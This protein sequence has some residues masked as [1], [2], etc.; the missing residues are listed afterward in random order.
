MK[1]SVP[2]PDKAIFG[3]RRVMAPYRVLFSMKG[4]LRWLIAGC[5]LGCI[6]TWL[7][8]LQ[9]QWMHTEVYILQPF[10]LAAGVFAALRMLVDSVAVRICGY[11]LTGLLLIVSYFEPHSAFQEAVWSDLF[12]VYVQDAGFLLH[13]ELGLVSG[14]GKTLL[15]FIGLVLMIEALYYLTIVK[16]SVSWFVAFLVS[17]V[18]V[19]QLLTGADVRWEAAG[20]VALGLS[21][22]SLTRLLQFY[23]EGKHPSHSMLTCSAI[24]L[25]VMLGLTGGTLIVSHALTTGY[26]GQSKVMDLDTLMEKAGWITPGHLS[27]DSLPALSGYDQDDRQLGQSL[28]P[29]HTSVFVAKTPHVTYWRGQSRALYSGKGWLN[30]GE[31][32][33]AASK[34][35]ESANFNGMAYAAGGEEIF[36]QT[37]QM[38]EGHATTVLFAGGPAVQAEAT[39][40]E[41]LAAVYYDSV[42][43]AWLSATSAVSDY[44]VTVAASSRNGS[45]VPAL[46]REDS[47]YVFPRPGFL[48]AREQ[49]VYTQLPEGLPV[50]VAELAREWTKE[51]ESEEMSILLLLREL[52]ARY[53]YR[54]TGSERP[55]KDMDFVDHFL[56]EQQWGYCDHFSTTFAVMLR[57]LGMPTRWVKGY[58]AGEVIAA[59]T[60]ETDTFE[61]EVRQ[62]DAHSW[63][64]VY[65]AGTGWIGLNPTPA[66]SDHPVWASLSGEPSSSETKRWSTADVFTSVQAWAGEWSQ[67]SM[68]GRSWLRHLSAEE[69]GSWAQA[70]SGRLQ[71]LPMLPDVSENRRISVAWILGIGL[72]LLLIVMAIAWRFGYP[73]RARGWQWWQRGVPVHPGRSP[74]QAVM[75]QLD[76]RWQRIF[77]RLGAR[78]DGE[79]LR[80]YASRISSKRPELEDR[81]RAW[82]QFDERFRYQERAP[83]RSRQEDV[84]QMTR[85]Y[86][87]LFSNSSYFS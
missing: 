30:D 27:T 52:S 20:T 41:E 13:G 53:S 36:Q 26:E 21:L 73:L 82:V 74:E 22:L 70:A 80:D 6:Y 25:V 29:D 5:L 17:Y 38:R 66:R 8:T 78:N 33:E 44:A 81:L 51:S 50:R 39:E 1:P 76:R 54:M 15:F 85:L 43:Q 14:Q 24:W 10:M 63:V 2:S 18:A 37:I 40:D 72:L 55:P 48:S 7:K 42:S 69:A 9:V 23:D 56:F 68:L 86:D 31:T 58:G 19:F 59:P 49:R 57:T 4:M 28:V 67:A 71:A 77:R 45:L 65:V 62:A 87:S 75:C 83:M 16:H 79:T 60:D 3:R 47:L 12:H 46:L 34:P 84:R 32:G 11:V 61:V 35:F 64:E